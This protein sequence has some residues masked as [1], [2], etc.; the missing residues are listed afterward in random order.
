MLAPEGRLIIYLLT[1]A[2]I[3]LHLIFGLVV[4]PL[5]IIVIILAWLYRDPQRITPSAPLGVIAPADGRIISIDNIEDK[6]LK[7]EALCISMRMNWYGA[8]TLRGV[9]EG[10]VMQH[11]LHRSEHTQPGRIQHIIWIQTDEKDDIVV[12]LHAS[13]WFSRMH[14]YIASGERLGQGK[15]CGFIPLGT[16]IDVYLP[17]RSRTAHKVGDSIQAGSDLLGEL[18]H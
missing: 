18:I 14:C 13:L 10:K 1:L 9:T 16:K 11:W 4:W 5:W 8:F 3:T 15:R 6:F 17:K 12:V 7:R 2:V